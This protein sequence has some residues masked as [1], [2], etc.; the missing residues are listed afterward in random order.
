MNHTTPSAAERVDREGLGAL[1]FRWR[2]Y[3]PLGVVAMLF[4]GLYVWGPTSVGSVRGWTL[5]G[6]AVAGLGLLLRFHAVGQAPPGTS[7]RHR[8]QYAEEL[9]TFGTYSV[10]RHPLYVGNIL[11]WVGVSL[12]SGWLA[13]AVVSGLLGVWMFVLIVRHED[14]FLRQRFGSR[15]AEWADVTPAFI[16]R[17]RLWRP[18]RRAFR[19]AKA[20]ASEYSTLHSIG[21]LALLFAALR[22]WRDTSTWSPSGLW[23]SL[24]LLNS[25]LYLGLR[26]WRA[27]R[28]PDGTDPADPSAHPRSTA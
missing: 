6:L 28:R 16:P 14:A 27:R 21:L 7:G 22:G 18:A 10:M 17:P 11:V 2:S 15:F 12:T 25:G 23:W 5:A 19:W 24:L 3:L 9:N 4:A 8:R 20:T 13:G 26:L 1:V